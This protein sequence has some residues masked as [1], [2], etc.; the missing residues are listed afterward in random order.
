MVPS[1]RVYQSLVHCAQCGG[2]EWWFREG[3]FGEVLICAQCSPPGEDTV[4]V[5]C[6]TT[7]PPETPCRRCGRHRWRFR[8]RRWVCANPRC[9]V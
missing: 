1:V 8:R 4:V 7:W 9:R 6:S 5:P 3:R 2:R